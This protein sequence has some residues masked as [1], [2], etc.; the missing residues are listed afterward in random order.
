[1]EIIYDVWGD[2]VNVAARMESAGAAGRINVS[3][4]VYHR[5]KA[6][7][8]FEHRGNVDAKNMG[9]LEMHFLLRIKAALAQDPEGYLPNEEFVAARERAVR[10][11]QSVA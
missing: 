9:Q 10:N 4:A 8:E 5:T 11:L 7:F 1:M 6:L 2:A 3:D